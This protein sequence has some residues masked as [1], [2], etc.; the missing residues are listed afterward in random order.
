MINYTTYNICKHIEGDTWDGLGSIT[1]SSSGIPLNLTDSYVEFVVKYS[2]ASPPVLSLTT[3]NSGV[4][5]PNPTQ[6]IV[7]I[8]PTAINI[9]PG[10]YNWYLTVQFADKRVK[11]YFRGIWQI[12]PNTLPVTDYE[13]RNY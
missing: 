3:Q 8:P 5:V 2:N 1:F 13:R 9:P 4:V 12:I 10:K 7:V 6:G 11:T